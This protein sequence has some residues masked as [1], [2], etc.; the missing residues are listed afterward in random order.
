MNWTTAAIVINF[1]IWFVMF[2]DILTDILRET[3]CSEDVIDGIYLVAK[4]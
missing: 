4:E 2:V 1:I 3:G